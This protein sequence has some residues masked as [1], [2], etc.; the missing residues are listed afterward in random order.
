MVLFNYHQDLK[1]RF[2]FSLI[3]TERPKVRPKADFGWT[4]YYTLEE[5][6]DVT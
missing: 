1:F 5:V 3:D 6:R 2:C 4:D